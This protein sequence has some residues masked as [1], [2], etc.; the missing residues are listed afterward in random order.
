MSEI[1]V[2]QVGLGPIGRL[3]TRYLL[4]RGGFEIVAAVDADMKLVGLDLGDLAEVGPL[5]VEV[6]G[7]VPAALEMVDADIAVVCTTSSLS[8]LEKQLPPILAHKLPVVS[9]CEELVY[10]WNSQPELARRIDA[11]ARQAGVPILGV[12]VNPGFLMDLLPVALS[13]VCQRVDQVTVER[14]QD[15]QFRRLPF[16]QKIGAGLTPAQFD[17]KVREGTLRHVG[18]TESMHMIAAAFGWKLVETE[19]QIEPVITDREV[20]T[21]D[22]TVAP[23][24]IVGVT[25]RGYGYCLGEN[26][27]DGDEPIAGIALIFRAAVGE[28]ESY[29]RIVLQ[30]VP[31][32][33]MRIPGGV[34]G[35][36]ATGAIVVNATRALAASAQNPDLPTRAQPGLRTMLDIAPICFWEP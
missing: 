29:E 35:D 20:R 24:Q 21:A 34:N 28:P 22:L 15:A 4:E 12:G 11:A 31:T 14:V 8:R 33:E 30:G 3:V 23:G 1:R 5:G 19:E 27:Y 25:Q 26:G 36:I 13:G 7:T 17:A 32:I 10:P 16:Q 2:L 6:S 18:L 9:T